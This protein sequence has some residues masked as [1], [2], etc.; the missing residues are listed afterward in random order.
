[1]IL[2][3]VPHNGSGKHQTPLKPLEDS[4]STY[5]EME[6]ISFRVSKLDDRIKGNVK[7]DDF[8]KFEKNMDKK[9]YL[10]GMDSKEYLKGMASK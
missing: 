6:Y 5:E 2:L 7:I 3:K 4:S 8:S 10:K 9:E 1:M